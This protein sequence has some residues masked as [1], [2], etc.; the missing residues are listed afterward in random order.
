[1]RGESPS[2]FIYFVKVVSNMPGFDMDRVLAVR[3]QLNNRGT[4][5]KTEEATK[6]WF[7]LPLLIAL[8]YD[9]FSTDI[10]PEFTLD[11]GIKRGERIDYALQVNNQPVAIV[12]CKGLDVTLTDKH[13]SQL[14][15]YF[16][17]CNVHIAILTNGD[18]Y[19]FY[20][21]S[22]KSNIMDLEPYF[23]IKLSS[24]PDS[25]LNKL[26]NYSK[27]AIQHIDIAK[28]VQYERFISEC[29][30]LVIGLRT[31]NIP[32]WVIEELARRSNVDE[33]D[34]PTLAGFLYREVVAQFG[35]QSTSI[36]PDESQTKKTK[37]EK[38]RS[39]IQ[40]NH[41]YVYNDFSDGDWTGHR[42]EYVL[43]CDEKFEI[44]AKNVLP[45]LLSIL[46]KKGII[47]SLDSIATQ[48][49]RLRLTSD[50]NFDNSK[51]FFAP[52]EG[53]NYLTYVVFSF[54]AIVP[55]ISECL[56][57]ANLPDDTV[58]FSFSS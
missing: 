10:I 12:E 40:I 2:I 52:V 53:T 16:S 8:G 36:E 29:R 5:P 35:N 44:P 43:I 23:K 18:D 14:F 58:K 26:Q 17:T 25:E 15:R 19:W 56:A 21:D 24:A 7:I 41:E 27:F 48:V 22:L 49:P 28:M 57:A 31:N 51:G 38:V 3:N 33:L 47:P 6:Q 34:R 37:K 55:I 4:T 32:S 1:M 54:M 9:P 20:T 50:P 30:D 13:T 45:L 39:S 11:V 46:V 42:L